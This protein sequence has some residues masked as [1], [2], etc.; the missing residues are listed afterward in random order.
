M[1]KKKILVLASLDSQ[2]DPVPQ[3]FERDTQKLLD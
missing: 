3:T 1:S 2:H